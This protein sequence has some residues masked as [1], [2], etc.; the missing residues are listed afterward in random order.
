MQLLLWFESIRNPFLNSIFSVITLLGG[1][2]VF[3]GFATF[4]YWCVNKKHGY[5]ILIS[6][7]FSTVLNQFLKLSFKV[8]RPWQ[9]MEGFTI[10]ES[11][12]GGAT[13]YSFPSGHAQN[14]VTTFGIVGAKARS[15][16]VKIIAGILLILVP[17]SRMY[18]G[19]HTP[20]DV[21]AGAGFAF[22][23]I[24]ALD[25]FFKYEKLH[26]KAMPWIIGA[27][28]IAAVSF[29]LYARVFTPLS[30]D[31]EAKSAVKNACTL[32]GCC[33]GLLVV[34]PLDTKVVKFSTAAK[35]YV[36][37]IKLVGGLCVVGCC[38]ALPKQ[39]LTFLL[40]EFEERIIR[41][42]LIVVTAGVLWPFTFRY[43]TK[44]KIPVFDKVGDKV[45]SI[46]HPASGKA[47][48][49]GKRIK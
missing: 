31:E 3:L 23:I 10:V 21:M 41:Y 25:H 34:Y 26:K 19:V 33:F 37:I 5:L 38:Y 32:L 9:S 49:S 7:F 27:V 35:W 4:V 30:S 2:L 8:P 24:I 20:W 48:A 15:L 6:G 28:F 22:I 1:E 42:F 43:I 17:V 16:A 36:Q 46:I 11:A 39:P 14:A 40:G 44:I 29:Y 45:Y 47:P 13:G 18:L 12:R